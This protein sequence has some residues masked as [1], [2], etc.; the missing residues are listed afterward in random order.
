MAHH[1]LVSSSAKG[2]G[3]DG[4][5]KGWLLKNAVCNKIDLWLSA[6]AHHLEM[7]ELPGCRSNAVVSAG[8]GGELY[9]VHEREPAAGSVFLRPGYG[10]YRLS[11]GQDSMQHAFYDEFGNKVF[12]KIAQRK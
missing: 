2:E 3:R 12:E 11:V 5:V 10:F 9:P 7:L 6:H 4:D 8:G 1:P